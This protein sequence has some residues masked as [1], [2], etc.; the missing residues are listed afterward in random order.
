[1]ASPYVLVLYYSR[2][3]ATE[4]LA[5][6]IA[7]GVEQVSGIEAR[8]RTVPS[9]STECEAVAPAI[10][11]DGALY[12]TEDDL[13]NCAGLIMGSPVRFGNMAAP[14]KYFID[15]TSNLWLTGQLINKPAGVFTS[16]NTLHGGQET[17]LMSM[18][19]PLI[20][21]GMIYCG[22]PFSEAGVHHTQAGGTPY[23]ASH[24]AQE[25]VE[26][27]QLNEHEQSVALAQGKRIAELALKLA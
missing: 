26:K 18:A 25:K 10:P 22:V 2:Y 8:I 13:K 16:G 20:H 21:H 3:G 5:R 4:Q 23:G 15:G 24:V 9:V 12:C 19:L 27:V 1:M 7:R 14:L 17:T 6:T 11:D